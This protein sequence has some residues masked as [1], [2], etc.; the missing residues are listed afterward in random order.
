M[1]TG[2]FFLKSSESYRKPTKKF[3]SIGLCDCLTATSWSQIDKISTEVEYKIWVWVENDCK[4]VSSPHESL[5]G[6]FGLTVKNMALLLGN[7]KTVQFLRFFI[8]YSNSR[9]ILD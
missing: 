6:P 2:L 9:H 7:R 5:K 8:H 3:L 1:Y 4:W